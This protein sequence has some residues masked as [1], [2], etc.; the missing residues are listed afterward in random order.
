MGEN[1][2]TGIIE[3]YFV[4]YKEKCVNFNNSNVS[5]LKIHKK[6]QKFHF[7]NII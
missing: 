1:K 2:H 4:Y 7:E 3:H 6:K 5:F